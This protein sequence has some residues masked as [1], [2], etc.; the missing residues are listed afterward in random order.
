MQRLMAILLGVMA[1]SANA[2]TATAWREA[3][4][5]FHSDPQW[6][7]SDGAFSIDLGNGRVL[8]SFGDTLV[9]RKPGD[10]RKN[11][12]FVRNTV[13]IMT[14]Y[15]PLIAQM[16]FYWRKAASRGIRT[17]IRLDFRASGAAFF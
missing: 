17:R 2:Q 16:K 6:L 10:G 13:A 5:I 15:D 7:G 14:G 9:A 12:A 8:W 1:A 3:E 4:R 11:A